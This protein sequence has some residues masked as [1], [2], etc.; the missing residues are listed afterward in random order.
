MGDAYAD[1]AAET[2]VAIVAVAPSRLNRLGLTSSAG[3]EAARAR[4]RSI[5]VAIHGAAR[6]GATLVYL[7]SFGIGEIRDEPGLR[8]TAQAMQW[9]CDLAAEHGL[10]VATENTLSAADNLRLLGFVDRPN[11]Q[12]LLDTQNPS[13]WGH[14]VAAYVDAL[15]PHLADQVHVKDGR[16]GRMGN[17]ALGD[18]QAGFAETAAALRGHGFDGT[19]ISEN[20]YA[21]EAGGTAAHDVAV[22]TRL[23]SNGA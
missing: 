17:A 20:D 7:P 6:L 1:A 21:G 9:A 13:E 22:L 2:G 11:A 14:D 3:P 23:F 19:L 8:R 5:A 16:D 10:E 4:E 12:V 15:W 18:G